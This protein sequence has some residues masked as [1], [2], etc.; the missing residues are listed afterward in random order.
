M[1]ID[2]SRILNNDIREISQERLE[3]IKS[4]AK[5]AREAIKYKCHNESEVAEYMSS[6]AEEYAYI[7][8]VNR[9]LSDDEK[10][11]LS[12]NIMLTNKKLA[13][14]LQNSGYQYKKLKAFIDI[15]TY[16]KRELS[17]GKSNAEHLEKYIN[18]SEKF[19]KKLL[20]TFRKQ[21]GKVT[22][23]QIINKLY[24][25]MAY[26]PELLKSK[27]E[28]FDDA[29]ENLQKLFEDEENTPIELMYYYANTDEKEIYINV[30]INDDTINNK[31]DILSTVIKAFEAFRERYTELGV[32]MHFSI[33]NSGTYSLANIDVDNVIFA[34][35]KATRGV[36]R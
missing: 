24:E 22:S 11:I 14:I 10:N 21:I 3:E 31:A 34:S 19:A 20:T 2:Y 18:T 5:A 26:E 36:K 32:K 27:E 29:K 12:A 9:D 13:D 17:E 23:S 33:R 35:E 4:R 16:I 25:V 8:A 1:L 28:R 6:H 15:V 7:K 30:I